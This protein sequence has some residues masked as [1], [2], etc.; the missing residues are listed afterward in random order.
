MPKLNAEQRAELDA[1]ARATRPTP[2]E[3]E[4]A[5]ARTLARADSSTQRGALPRAR[6]RL[7]WVAAASMVTL[8]L[9]SA[10]V[11]GVQWLRAK[12]RSGQPSYGQ[13]QYERVEEVDAPERSRSPR[14]S[15]RAELEGPE[16]EPERA[17][18]ST[19]LSLD[20]PAPEPMPAKG[21]VASTET[22]PEPEPEQDRRIG[23]REGAERS[24]AGDEAASSANSESTAGA[25]SPED[26]PDVVHAGQLAE[27]SRLLARARKALDAGDFASALD[28]A[29][30]HA[31]RHDEGELI[32]ER[33]IIEAVAA[34]RG[35]QRQRGLASLAA[36]RR[37]VANSPTLNKI[38]RTCGERE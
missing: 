24:R 16:A 32:E 37:R 1:Y 17:H 33:L 34:C 5:L 28:W 25:S 36:L 4:R 6:S 30:E 19:S 21:E 18:P 10:A 22:E 20:E 3:V 11:A 9:A 27:E 15:G 13:A 14:E 23:R 2:A 8:A 35:G 12:D 38:E 7:V 29:D 26:Q 31:R